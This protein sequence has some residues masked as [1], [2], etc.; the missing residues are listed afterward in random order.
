M[1]GRN[2]RTGYGV[3]LAIASLRGNHY[4]ACFEPRL[5]PLSKVLHHTCFICGQRCKCWSR[6]PKLTS[7]VISDVKLI[8]FIYIYIFVLFSNAFGRC[9]TKDTARCVQS[10]EREMQSNSEETPLFYTHNYILL[11]D[12]KHF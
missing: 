6:R 12:V 8:I 7:S 4:V 11:K 5:A 3:G 2:G 9:I 1:R 10:R